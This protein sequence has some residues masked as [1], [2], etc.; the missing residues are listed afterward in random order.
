MKG[1]SCRGLEVFDFK[2]EDEVPE[3]SARKL[4]GK[5]GKPRVDDHAGLKY[6]FLECVAH[7]SNL[8]S[9]NSGDLPCV[10][11]DDPDEKNCTMNAALGM[12]GGSPIKESSATV[13]FA[14]QF[15]SLGDGLD[16]YCRIDNQEYRSSCSEEEMRT[17]SPNASSPGESPSNSALSESPSNDKSVDLNSDA[18]NANEQASTSD[19]EEDGSLNGHASNFHVDSMELVGTNGALVVFP[20]YVIYRANYYMEPVL[21]FSRTC[22]KIEGSTTHGKERGLTLECSVDDIVNISC[23]WFNKVETVLIKLH[24][25]SKDATQADSTNSSSGIE[26]LKFAVVDPN[27][28]KKQDV[29]TAL[30]VKYSSIWDFVIAT[31]TGM[32]VVDVSHQKRY[33][34]NFDEPFEE[35][36]YPKGDSDAVS[37]SKRDVDLLQPETFINDTII[38]FYIKYLKKQIHQ[39]DMH[40]FHFFNSFF[41]RKLADMDKDPSSACDGRAAFLRVRKWTRKINLFEKDYIFIPVNFNLHWSLI[42]ICHPGEVASFSDEDLTKAAKVPCI[43]HMDSIRGSHTGLKNLVQSYLWEE[44]KEKGND[45]SEHPSSKFSNMRFVPLDLPQQ[46]NSFD[47]GLFLLHYLELFLAE[48]PPTFNPTKISKFSRYLNVDWFQPMEASFKRTLIQK[49]IYELLNGQ[50]RNASPDYSSDKPQSPEIL[51]TKVENRYSGN[52]LAGTSNP[53]ISCHSVPQADKGIEIDLLVDPS[54]RNA[55]CG[56]NESGLVLRELFEP[57]TSGGSFLGHCQSFNEQSYY[58]LDNGV[59]AMEAED[60]EIGAQFDYVPY[61][62][63]EE[64]DFREMGRSSPQ[65]DGVPYSDDGG[66]TGPHHTWKSEIS[67]MGEE[68]DRVESL[69]T[70]AHIVEDSEEIKVLENTNH[71]DEATSPSGKFNT[72]EHPS[73]LAENREEPKEQELVA[74]ASC[75]GPLETQIILG[76]QGLDDGMHV[77]STPEPENVGSPQHRPAESSQIGADLNGSEPAQDSEEGADVVREEAVE[78]PAA[79]VEMGD[80][81]EVTEL[82]EE[83]RDAKRRRINPPLKGEEGPT[84]DVSEDLHL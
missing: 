68:E 61:G 22:V 75:A 19:I 2:E 65:A 74:S 59:S 4:L 28:F 77:K 37:I 46:E 48:A 33:F 13:T 24:L 36:I 3:E 54:V 43:L 35:L 55:Q 5:F 66:F 56:S 84:S 25:I 51:E 45:A 50:S 78:A 76:S 64:T 62:T 39:E 60:A 40:R 29:I 8:Q 20:E 67:L 21:S 53:I 71:G 6:K 15:D 47:C 1:S 30:N 58:P 27:W 38:D 9:K 10:D 12:G 11:V 69:E 7:G 26:E 73:P 49:L 34:P 80:Q 23:Q 31:D 41:F 72:D 14:M 82:T 81:E 63:C 57:G 32:D 18:E 16:T 70:S 17:S 83:E 44:W 42:V 52:S 79:V